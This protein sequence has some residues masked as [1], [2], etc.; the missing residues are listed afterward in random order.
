MAVVDAS[1]T[2]EGTSTASAT[3][4][5][6]VVCSLAFE[7]GSFVEAIGGIRQIVSGT[8]VGESAFAWSYGVDAAATF[9]GE[10]FVA[11][12]AGVIVEAKALAVG[13]SRFSYEPPQVIRGWSSFIIRTVVD[14]HL[15][16]LRAT[17]LG[18]KSFR[19]LQPFQRG[20]L[21]VLIYDQGLPSVPYRVTYNLAQL[22]PDGSRR[23]VGPRERVPASGDT[24]EFYVTGCAGESGQPGQWVIEW[25]FQ[26]TPQA[27][28]ETA[29][30][31]F[32]VLDAVATADPRERLSRK[33]KYGWS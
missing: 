9:T 26:R 33:T 15:P 27:A 19:W 13:R 8:F 6:F 28:V 2:A 3:E 4:A 7:G 24:G 31:R 25:K 18:P 1:G 32:Q 14:R 21:P 12:D 30:M 5:V 17:T 11:C 22:R 29:E 10:A 20:D 23:Y 16:S